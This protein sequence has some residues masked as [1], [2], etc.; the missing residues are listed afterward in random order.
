MT[1]ISGNDLK[2]NAAF[3]PT[4]LLVGAGFVVVCNT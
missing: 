3:D 2:K 1:I 4:G